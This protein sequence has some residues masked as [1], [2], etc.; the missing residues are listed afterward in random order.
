MAKPPHLWR[1]RNLVHAVDDAA[2]L[3]LVRGKG[4][5]YTVDATAGTVTNK[6]GRTLTPFVKAGHLFVRLYLNG[7]RRGIALGKL[8][9]M[10]VTGVEV[11]KGFDIHHEDENPENNGWPNLY[12]LHRDDHGKRHAPAPGDPAPF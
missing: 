6:K 7:K 2:V 8:V 4:R 10:S 5:A 9:W 1:N 12:C 3:R 11:P